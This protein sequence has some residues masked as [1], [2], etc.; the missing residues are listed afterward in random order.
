MNRACSAGVSRAIRIS[1]SSSLTVCPTTA[2]T[3]CALVGSSVVENDD[4]QRSGRVAGG[5]VR[6]DLTQH[7]AAPT[8]VRRPNGR[9]SANSA[10]VWRLWLARGD[11]SD[12]LAPLPGAFVRSGSRRHRGELK[13]TGSAKVC[14][15]RSVYRNRPKAIGIMLAISRA[16]RRSWAATLILYLSRSIGRTS[17]FRSCWTHS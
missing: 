4:F 2:P 1:S 6:Q 5:H 11:S 8:R 10:P 3:I 13:A 12:P 9:S 14:R 15:K 7:G 17:F 16:T